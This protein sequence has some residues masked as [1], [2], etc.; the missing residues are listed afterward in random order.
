MRSSFLGQFLATA[1]TFAAAF[2]TLPPRCAL[3]A[4]L[5]ATDLGLL[6][7]GTYL[8]GNGGGG[9]YVNLSGQVTGVGDDTSH[10][11]NPFLYDGNALPPLQSILQSGAAN[12]S[13][14]GINNAGQVYG[15]YK[16]TITG[17]N[18][19]MFLYDPTAATPFQNILPLAAFPLG[20]HD[21]LPQY[22]FRSPGHQCIG[23]GGRLLPARQRNPAR[24]RLHFRLR[25]GCP[26]D[27]RLGGHGGQQR[28]QWTQQ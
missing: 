15:A 8:S 14:S 22:Q 19:Q 5:T 23:P 12:G 28:A 17:N 26:I 3:A 21:Q 16:G 1:A 9:S 7:G 11:G 4:T 25:W 6:P 2:V 20:Q 18:T 10:P 13:G 24:I 27:S